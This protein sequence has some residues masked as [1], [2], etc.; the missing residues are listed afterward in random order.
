MDSLTH[1]RMLSRYNRWMNE[2]IYEAGAGLPDAERKADRGAYF[3][4]I[5]GTLNHL[6]LTDRLWLGR[7]TDSPFRVSRLDQELYGDFDEMRRERS[8]TDEQIDAWISGLSE[9]RLAG[10]FSFT[11]VL[12]SQ[13]RR[14]PLWQVVLHLFNHQ[15]HHR[16][17]VTTLLMQAGR[18]PGVTDLLG[19]PA[20][21]PVPS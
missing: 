2:R 4:S 3:R 19:L 7:F 11:S 5:H 16:G 20:G 12:D 9:A 18:D 17:Q 15:T 13:S 10:P 1:F 6:L 21:G 14:Y 8:R